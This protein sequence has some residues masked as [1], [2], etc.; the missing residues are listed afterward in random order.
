MSGFL[1]RLRFFF[2][3]RPSDEADE[4]L[5]FHL[6][7]AAQANIAAGMT[8][9]EARRQAVI[10][11]G[12]MESAREQ[13]FAQR[14]GWWM[15]TVLQDVR[16]ALRGFRRNPLFTATV[17]ATLALGI[18]STTAVFSVVDPI[19][20]RSLPYAHADRLVSVGLVHALQREPFMLG[21]FYYNWKDNQKPFEALTSQAYGANECDLTQQNR[22]Q[23]SCTAVEANFLPTLGV[24]PVLGRNFLPEENRP[25][26][27]QVAIISY[28]LWVSHFNRDPSILNKLV[29]IDDKPVRVVGVLP[30]DFE[31]PNLDAVDVLRPMWSWTRLSNADQSMGQFCVPLPGSIPE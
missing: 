21:G 16:Y 19:L 29:E 28:R 31:L 23:L 13:T 24:A 1:T 3:R 8:P 25:N 20:F 2:R 14:P 12:G 17:I 15:E 10:A 27:P 11:F 26:G 5:Q 30:Q 7:Q 9:E 22:A 18:G 4:E 6:E